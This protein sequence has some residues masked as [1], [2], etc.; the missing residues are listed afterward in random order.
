VPVV[1]LDVIDPR[2]GVGYVPGILGMNLFTDRDLIL[3][4]G[5]SDPSV[6]ISPQQRWIANSNGNFGDATKW[7]TTIPNDVDRVA[8]FLSAISAPRTINIDANY[9]VG[10]INFDNANSYT[11]SGT[12]RLTLNSSEGPAGISVITGNH[13]ISAPMTFATDTSL[14]VLPAGSKLTLSNDVIATG[15]TINKNGDGTAEMKNVRAGGLELDGGKLV[16]LHNSTANSA[17]TASDVKSISATSG[18]IDLK[19]NALVVRGAAS[20]GTGTLGT[21]NGSAYTGVTGLIAAG[22]N[23]GTQDGAGIVTTESAAVA[24]NSLTS[25]AVA[26]AEDAGLAGGAFAGQSVLVGDV[27]VKYTYGGDANLDGIINGDDYFQIDSAFP[28]ALHGWFNGDFN[29]DGTIN[30]DDYFIIDSNFPAQGAAFPSDIPDQSSG[31]LAV[32]EPASVAILLPCWLL[33]NRRRRV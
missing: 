14:T 8:N 23:G 25:L 22:Y 2:D 5:L 6:A 16:V 18:R 4:G 17:A 13:T 29:Y 10:S 27:L 1:V 24:P 33:L 32:P 12:G 19:N 31:L 21:W 3:N 30:G 26:R 28:A 20:G 11:L 7:N 15:V 9:I